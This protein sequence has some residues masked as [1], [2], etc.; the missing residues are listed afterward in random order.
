VEHLKEY[1]VLPKRSSAGK[2]MSYVPATRDQTPEARAEQDR[3]AEVTEAALAEAEK[4]LEAE[5]RA[6]A[7]SDR[8]YDLVEDAQPAEGAPIRVRD[9]GRGMA[10]VAPSGRRR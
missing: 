10:G 3:L 9:R 2:I 6:A 1:G 7:S 5:Q 8:V 4:E